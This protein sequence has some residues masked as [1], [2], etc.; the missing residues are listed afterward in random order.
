MDSS[1]K[2][3]DSLTW[4]YEKLYIERIANAKKEI[5]KPLNEGYKESPEITLNCELDEVEYGLYKYTLVRIYDVFKDMDKVQK[6]ITVLEQEY[7][8]NLRDNKLL[9]PDSS[10]PH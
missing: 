3:A 10:G 9:F 5:F 1:E 2:N 8:F 4:K 6:A 7:I